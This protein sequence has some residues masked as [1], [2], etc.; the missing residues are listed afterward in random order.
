MSNAANVA[1]VQVSAGKQTMAPTW[2]TFEQRALFY[3][4]LSTFYL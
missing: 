3:A 4:L 1:Y 2:L